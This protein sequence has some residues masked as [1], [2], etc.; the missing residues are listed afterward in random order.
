MSDGWTPEEW[1]AERRRR[2]E[3]WE[4]AGQSPERARRLV[5]VGV[6]LD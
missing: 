5:A 4:A 6:L 1:L 2:C 3:L